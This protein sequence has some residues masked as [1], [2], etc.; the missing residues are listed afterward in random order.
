MKRGYIICTTPR[1]GSTLLC[2]MLAATGRAGYPESF[3]HEREVMREWAAEWG[4]PDDQAMSQVERER[5]YLQA[6]VAAGRGGTPLFAMR[7]QQAYLGGLV[8][9]LDRCYAG[10]PS[11][12]D[13]LAAAFGDVLYVHLT[14]TDKVAQAVSLV[15]ARQS[16]LWHRN[17]DGTERERSAPPQELRYDHAAI[18][19]EIAVQTRADDDWSGWFERQRITPHR[20]IYEEFV[21][22]PAM[23]VVRLCEAVGVEP[24]AAPPIAPG[25][26]RLADAISADWIA[27]YGAAVFETRDHPSA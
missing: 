14:R 10:F 2:T 24:P 4:L 1:S 19:R 16:G 27:R 9:M 26:A 8:E 5:S 11:D 18:A 25:L 15:K 7:L 13:R 3:Y 23:A 12:A 17:A 6:V 20:I 21:G 22:D